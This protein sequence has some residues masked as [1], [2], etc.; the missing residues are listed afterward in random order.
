MLLSHVPGSVEHIKILLQDKGGS[1]ALT[2][3]DNNLA[4]VLANKFIRE[5]NQI[6]AEARWTQ[7]LV[8]I[9]GESYLRS[10]R[11]KMLG[12]LLSEVTTIYY[13]KDTKS[14]ISQGYPLQ[15][16]KI[17]SYVIP[18]IHVP[19]DIKEI[20]TSCYQVSTVAFLILQHI[21]HNWE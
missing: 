20:N 10:V 9:G 3:P 15:V 7:S 13:D 5:L 6:S 12:M 19:I 18:V 4:E 21:F 1:A 8:R 16:R 14:S 11:G 2:I 17:C